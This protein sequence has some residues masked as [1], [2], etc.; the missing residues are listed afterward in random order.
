MDNCTKQSVQYQG[1]SQLD[2]SWQCVLWDREVEEDFP[3]ALLVL[4]A[5]ILII[6]ARTQGGFGGVR[7]NP[8]FRRYTLNY[9]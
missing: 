1:G 2:L 6:Q 3:D 8:P 4:S 9:R 5:C 7:T